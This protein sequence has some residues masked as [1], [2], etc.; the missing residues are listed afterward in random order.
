MATLGDLER[1]VMDLLW[2][3]D[4]PLSASALR[5]RLATGHGGAPHDVAPTTVLT[6]LSRLEAKGFVDRTRERRPHLYQATLSRADHTA[7]LMLEVLGSARDRDAALAR[8]VG[9]VSAGEADTLRRLLAE[10]HPA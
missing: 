6:V 1:S 2:S 9:T 5:E 7:D 8:F 3:S 4:E 10:R